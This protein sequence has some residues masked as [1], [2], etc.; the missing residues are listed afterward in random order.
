[1]KPTLPENHKNSQL[2]LV[3]Q[4]G[5]V[6][7][8]GRELAIARRA[9][10][11]IGYGFWTWDLITNTFTWSD[12]M[13]TIFGLSPSTFKPVVGAILPF[14]LPSER[15]RVR[16]ELKR[17]R[18]DG[19]EALFNTTICR[20]DKAIR[21]LRVHAKAESDASGVP[22][23]ISGV[24]QDITRETVTLLAVSEREEKYRFLFESMTLGAFY[25]S[26]DG[27]LIDVNPAALKIFGLTR[28]QFLGRTSMH[29]EW[30]VISESGEAIKGEDH[31]SMLALRSGKPIDGMVVGVYNPERHEY[32]WGSVNAIPIFDEGA[33][34]PRAVFATFLDITKQR[35]TLLA[36]RRSEE[37]LA[38]ACKMEAIGTLAGGIAHEF[39]NILGIILGNAEIAME[40]IEKWHPSRDS[41]KEIR[42]A[43]LR[44]KDVVA[45]LLSF[46][47]K[48]VRERRFI[49]LQDV[50]S[51]AVS[52]LNATLP[53]SIQLICRIP[54]SLPL[55]VADQ[56]QI[57]Q[58]LINLATNAYHAIAG[59]GSITF[60]VSEESYDVATEVNHFT[61]E[62]GPYLHV[63][64]TDTGEGIS[65]EVL[66]R[67]FDPYFTTKDV[68]KG[69]GMG[70][71]VVHGVIKNH[72]GAVW[73]ESTV[74]VGTT[75]H[76][77]LPVSTSLS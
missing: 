18:T 7:Q 37:Q 45:K 25:Q 39:N 71:S 23:Y 75:A 42:V 27:S 72:S 61:L 48:T 58:V 21:H 12:L 76:L 77:L 15:P 13:Y 17:L 67:V 68:G 8:M 16:S 46:A 30:R 43:T 55:I 40:D 10:D 36:L 73:L 56:N 52:L 4:T 47:R 1:M 51:E 6:E 41:L 63:S 62:P 66:P 64:I 11:L 9:E 22:V 26:S 59:T 60:S 14:H 32:R 44:A 35:N 54:S 50:I 19:G 49:P 20:G 2:P 70:L 38:H 53:S 33:T 57:H 31:P 65:P 69:S 5:D 74:G 3:Q 24:I 34:E 28:E 29:P